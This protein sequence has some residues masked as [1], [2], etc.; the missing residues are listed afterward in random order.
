MHHFDT[1]SP[2]DPVFSWSVFL[3]F[4]V[5]NCLYVL[6]GLQ[7]PAAVRSTATEKMKPFRLRS[8]N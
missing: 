4:N 7:F 2:T 5:L 8:G 6:N 1:P 3:F